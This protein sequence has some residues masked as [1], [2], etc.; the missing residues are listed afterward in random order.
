MSESEARTDWQRRI[1]VGLPQ[2]RY[3]R[4]VGRTHTEP[5]VADDGPH[6][7]QPVGT[8]TEHWSGRVDAHASRPV[9]T[10]HPNLHLRK[11]TP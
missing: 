3:G 11:A 1:G 10:V 7:G 4:H 9:T 5:V 8:R 6:R 2:H